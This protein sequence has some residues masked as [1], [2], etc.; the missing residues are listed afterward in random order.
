MDY[1]TLFGPMDYSPPGSSV[2]GILQARTLE[3]AASSFS[4]GWTQVSHTAGRFF[5]VWATSEAFDNGCTS[6]H[7]HQQCTRVLFST[8]SPTII[9]CCLFDNSHSDRCEVVSHHGSDLHFPDDYWC[10]TFS[11]ACWPFVR[12][13]WKDVCVLG[14]FLNCLFFRCWILQVLCI[15]WILTPCQT[16]TIFH[17]VGGPFILLIV[18][19]AAK[20]F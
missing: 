1:R 18:S 14:P 6:L 2:H 13:L 19:F 10:W 7:S 15:F 16:N 3:W 17:S 12:L 8:F 5:T 20:A 4:R 9:I 11:C